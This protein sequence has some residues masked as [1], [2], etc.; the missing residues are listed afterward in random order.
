[1]SD[2]SR[3]ADFGSLETHRIHIARC[4][5]NF[6]VWS[7]FSVSL[8][9]W[10]EIQNVVRKGHVF[11]FR[12]CVIHLC[13]QPSTM[14]P[15][16]SSAFSLTLAVFA[17][18]SGAPCVTSTSLPARWG[19]P[20]SLSSSPSLDIYIASPRCVVNP[21]LLILAPHLERKVQPLPMFQSCR[22]AQTSHAIGLL[23]RIYL[24]LHRSFYFRFVALVLSCWWQGCI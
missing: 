17:L 18:G 20:A 5:V 10:S 21:R 6:S 14:K 24:M 12:L 23:V 2:A 7:L 16:G 8:K 3:F 4:L 13:I 19:P 9:V 15:C 11:S 1:M 22:L